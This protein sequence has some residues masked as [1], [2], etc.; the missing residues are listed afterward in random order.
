MVPLVI[1]AE[2]PWNEPAQ[3]LAWLRPEFASLYPEI[4]AGL[5]VTA[6]SAALVIVG[7]VMGGSRSWPG[8]GSRVLMNEHF[9]FR[10]GTTRTDRWRG[11]GTRAD[12]P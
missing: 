6:F 9:L 4:P 10:G 7:G 11:P 1:P 12:D 3:R 2:W 8:P 5:W